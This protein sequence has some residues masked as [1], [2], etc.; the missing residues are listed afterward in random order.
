MFTSSEVTRRWFRGINQI[1]YVRTFTCFLLIEFGNV[2][3]H[4]CM[5]GETLMHSLSVLRSLHDRVVR[6][7]RKLRAAADHYNESQLTV[8]LRLLAIYLKRGFRPIDAL[9]LG[10]ADPKIKRDVLRDCVKKIRVAGYR[11][12]NPQALIHLTEDKNVFA[13]YC[14]VRGIPTPNPFRHLRSS[15]D[16]APGRAGA[17]KEGRVGTRCCPAASSQFHHKTSSRS[18]WRGG[19]LVGQGRWWLSRSYSATVFCG[20]SLRAVLCGCQVRPLRSATA[21]Y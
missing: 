9:T 17:D 21:T 15:Y 11:K 10:L 2:T 18:I 5:L 14:A 20:R 7:R 19:H 8:G 6:L 4:R 13:A 3:S 1:N 12:L 16:L